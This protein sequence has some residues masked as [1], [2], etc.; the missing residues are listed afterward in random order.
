MQIYEQKD[1][2]GGL[3]LRSDQFQLSDNE[4]PEMLNVEVDPRGGVFSRGGMERIHS[5]NI[6]GTWSPQ[7]LTPFYGANTN[8]ML[9]NHQR[10]QRWVPASNTFTNLE[11]SA[12]NPIAAN[13]LHGACFAPWGDTLYIAT[14]TGGAAG[15]TYKWNGATTYATALGGIVLNS[16]WLAG[17]NDKFPQAEHII[18][19]TNKMFAANV[20]TEGVYH[21]NRVHFSQE[22][23]PQKWEEDDYFDILGG[24]EGIT[25]MVVVN[26][27]LVIFKQYAIYALYGYD[28]TDYRLVEVSTSIGC[29]DHH[30]MVQTE[31]GVYFYSSQKGLHFFDG[32]QIVD[33]F[34][35][36]RPAYDLGYINSAAAE[37][38]SVSWVGRRVWLSL[39]YSTTGVGAVV[40]TVNIVFDPSM[41]SYTMFQTYDNKGVVGGTDYRDSSG[42]EYRL[43]CHPTVPCVLNVDRYGLPY[44]KIDVDGSN[45]GFNTI[46]RTKWFDAGSYLQRKMFR[47][48]DLVMRETDTVQNITVDVYHDFQEADGAEARSFVLTQTATEGGLVW[49]TGLWAYEPIGQ[50]P[51]GSYWS[52]EVLG[53]TIK[54]AKNLGL[55]KAVQLRFS[56]ELSKPWGINS[57]G[58][59]WQ[60]RRVKG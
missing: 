20:V 43:M 32:S 38:V 29:S 52:N 40:A 60:P 35:P 39:P 56:G 50:D 16:D 12:G 42:V 14:G 30:A 31:T 17:T 13:G 22:S 47:R 34:E 23:L 2:T 9:A 58:Y 37:A 25:G 49:D 46:Y 36:L 19:H 15:A 18:V 55:C 33:L 26:G 3:N 44:D 7:K 48:P 57:I 45:D 59:K 11:F 28:N 8:L 6:A 41:R 4:S 10:V 54:T 51:Y 21:R 24:G 5:V 27:V 1:F 53:G